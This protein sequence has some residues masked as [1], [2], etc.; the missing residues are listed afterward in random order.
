M[1]AHK[2]HIFESFC[3]NYSFSDQFN[4]IPFLRL[5]HSN[6]QSEAGKSIRLKSFS[7]PK[8]LRH[9]LYLLSRYTKQLSKTDKKYEKMNTRTLTFHYDKYTYTYIYIHIYICLCVYVSECVCVSV[10]VVNNQWFDSEYVYKYLFVN[11]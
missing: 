9:Q 11:Q 6:V 10:C 3:A 5:F 1:H 8:H 4:R 2:K 7:S